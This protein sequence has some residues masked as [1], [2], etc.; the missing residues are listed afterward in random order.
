L[1]CWYTTDG[2]AAWDMC[3]VHWLMHIFYYHLQIWWYEFIDVD[4]FCSS[5]LWIGI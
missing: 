2:C 3:H 4:Y 5:S 1:D